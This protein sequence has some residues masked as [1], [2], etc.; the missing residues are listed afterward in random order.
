VYRRFQFIH[1][2]L[3]RC[4]WI[5]LA[6]L[7][8][9]SIAYSEDPIRVSSGSGYHLGDFREHIQLQSFNNDL[10]VTRV[11]INYRKI[12]GACRHA[13]ALHPMQGVF[14]DEDSERPVSMP[15][16][17]AQKFT[18]MPGCPPIRQIEFETNM[19]SFSYELQ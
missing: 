3:S 5:L 14:G 7:L 19:G 18:T 2:I 13:I 11:T 9:P 6:V 4:L 8:A 16:G 12:R 1:N 15:F 17:K 10:V